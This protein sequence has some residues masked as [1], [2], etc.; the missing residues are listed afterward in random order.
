MRRRRKSLACEKV[1]I[2]GRQ[3]DLG[4]GLAKG[5]GRTGERKRESGGEQNRPQAT[6]IVAQAHGILLRRS[7]PRSLG[8]LMR[9]RFGCVRLQ[10]PLRFREVAAAPVPCSL[11][12]KFS[13][14][15][16]IP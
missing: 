9:S 15:R 6:S 7:S 1:L 11:N 10:D 4:Y 8:F 13:R 5:F 2:V 12:A 3:I 14:G 16:K